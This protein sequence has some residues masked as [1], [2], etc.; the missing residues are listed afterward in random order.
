MISARPDLSPFDTA[1]R[2]LVDLLEAPLWQGPRGTVAV[3]EVVELLEGR[4]IA[5]FVA[6]GAVRDCLLGERPNDVDLCVS[7][8][9]ASCYDHVAA[10]FGPGIL[11]GCNPRFGVCRLGGDG[12]AHVDVAMMRDIGCAKGARSLFDIHWTP[13]PSLASE[14]SVRDFTINALFWRRGEGVLDPGG[15]GLED[16]A[17]RRLSVNMHPWKADIDHRLPLR[18]ALFAGRGFDPDLDCLDRF[19]RSIDEAIVRFGEGIEA[20]LE[21]LTG[22]EESLLEQIREFCRVEGA[23]PA[24]VA[25]LRLPAGPPEE[26]LQIPYVLRNG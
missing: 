18:I 11:Q 22:G 21:E 20:F 2:R 3:R 14:A 9:I 23:S 7:G 15:R 13:S 8:D 25:R 26:D 10:A 12:F 1:E 17:V 19:R 16:L 4:G 5:V 24:S 6:G